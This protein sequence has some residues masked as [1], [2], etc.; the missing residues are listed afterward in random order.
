MKISKTKNQTV[1]SSLGVIQLEI[2]GP[3]INNLGKPK[4][5]QPRTVEIH[6][7]V[8]RRGNALDRN[9]IQNAAQAFIE[10]C[11]PSPNECNFFLTSTYCVPFAL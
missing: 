11:C 3:G 10:T 1:T 6:A 8:E 2:T 7:R 5:L 4:T 9:P